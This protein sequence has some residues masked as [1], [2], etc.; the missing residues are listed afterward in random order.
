MTEFHRIT[1]EHWQNALGMASLV[2][3]LC[4]FV[5]LVARVL[6]IPRPKL[7]HLENLPLDD[8]SSKDHE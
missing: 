3:F 8:D 4:L 7:T 2:L 6:S 1:V 5:L